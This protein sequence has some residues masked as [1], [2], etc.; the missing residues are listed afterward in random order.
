VSVRNG[1]RSPLRLGDLVCEGEATLAHTSNS[2]RLDSELLAA[3]ALG[4]SRTRLLVSLRDV[5]P[6]SVCDVFRAY[7]ARRA[8]GEPI[9]YILGEK[10]FWGLDFKVSPD[11]LVPRPET[12]LVVEEGLRVLK[13]TLAP[14]LLDLGTGSG[15]IAISLV[16]TLASQGKRVVCDAIDT[17]DAA[18]AV[19]RRNAAYNEVTERI[20][21]SQSSWFSN[22]A[23]FSPPYDLI[24]AN[25][26]YID[27]AENTP[28]ELSFEPRSA[29]YSEDGGLKDTKEIIEQGVPLL[30][31][32][33][34][35]LC[36]VGAGKRVLLEQYF[37]Q[38]SYA[39]TLLGDDSSQ[40]RFTVIRVVSEASK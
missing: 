11:V 16:K 15:C 33:G 26:P 12:E 1:P 38:R 24:V 28:V 40:D 5:A 9:A 27:P 23:A 21:F 22:T 37:A 14:K 7:V 32:G 17:S 10:E 8:D 18:L 36:E 2:P 6:E 19:A 30:A 13:D 25:P 34:V 4:M 29:L 20:R 39:Y 31:P 3:H 35:L